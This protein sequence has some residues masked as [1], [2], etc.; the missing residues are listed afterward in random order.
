VQQLISPVQ[1]DLPGQSKTPSPINWISGVGKTH[2]DA[3]CTGPDLDKRIKKEMPNWPSLNISIPVNS[4]TSEIR[5]RSSLDRFGSSRWN[6]LI[7]SRVV[8][9]TV[10]GYP[11]EAWVQ[12]DLEAPV[13]F[14][15]RPKIR[16]TLSWRVVTRTRHKHGVFNHVGTGPQF[17]LC[18]SYNFGWNWVFELQ[19]Y[20]DMIS[21]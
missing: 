2:A 18:G 21:T 14:Q 9:P 17:Q 12:K 16:P 6:W 3:I 10:P 19:S 15:T 1:G 7:N 13:C 8:L 4:S 11:V 20:R 5:L